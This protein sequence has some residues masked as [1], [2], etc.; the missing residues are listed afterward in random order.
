MV[1][2]TVGVW[3]RGVGGMVLVLHNKCISITHHFSFLF[4][5]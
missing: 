3:S 4:L 2:G 5:A 1:A